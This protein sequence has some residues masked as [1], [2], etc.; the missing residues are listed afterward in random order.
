MHNPFGYY[1]PGCYDHTKKKYY[2][3]KIKDD[4]GEGWRCPR[5]NYMWIDWAFEKAWK[6]HLEDLKKE[7]VIKSVESE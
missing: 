3:K 1:C 6:R 4:T 7:K 5:C 2:L